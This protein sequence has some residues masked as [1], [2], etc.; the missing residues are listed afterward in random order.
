MTD[1]DD[2]ASKAK[3]LGKTWLKDDGKAVNERMGALV[4]T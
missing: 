1:S 3:T 4:V 2:K